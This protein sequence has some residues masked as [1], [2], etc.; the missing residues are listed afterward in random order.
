MIELSIIIPHYNTPLLLMKLLESIPNIPE[1]EVLVIDDNST[2]EKEQY[3]R[4][5]DIN[6]KRNVRFYANSVQTKGAGNARNIG[7]SHACGEWVLFADADD[8][9]VD[10]F[11]QILIPYLHENA[12]IIYFEST[13]IVLSTGEKSDRHVFYKE[14]VQ[15]FCNMP[16]PENE[17]RLRYTYWSPCAKIIRH[18]M[19]NEHNIR[20]DGTLHSNDMMFSTK[21]GHY[22]KKIKAIKKTIYV[23]TQSDKSLTASKEEKDL[24]ERS[25]V[26]CNYY[27]FLHKVLKRGE[28]RILGYNIKDYIYFI[29]YKMYIL[30]LINKLTK[31]NR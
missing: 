10:G 8:Y 27:F 5:I 29:L 4:C 14:L 28:M 7:L 31:K 22:A 1:I 16:S 30:P 23:I 11:W 12:D 18:Q 6:Q 19:I 26:F 3:Q 24:K 2:E 25:D 15:K 13:S 9:F 20:F 21:T 17:L